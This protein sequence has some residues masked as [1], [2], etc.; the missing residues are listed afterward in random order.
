MTTGSDTITEPAAKNPHW[1]VKPPT[2]NLR[3]TGA[4]YMDSASRNTEAR[5]NSFHA[6]MN[7]NSAVIAMAGLASGRMMRKKM[8]CG[9]APSMRADSSMSTGMVSKYPLSIHTQKG[10]AVVA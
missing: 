8:V 3:P 5:M 2:K 6:V 1:E 4:V 7:E 10:I 9:L